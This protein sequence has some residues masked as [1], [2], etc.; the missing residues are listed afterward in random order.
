MTQREPTR[1]GEV[2]H[3]QGSTVTVAL[4]PDLAGT[5]P[6]FRGRLQLVG[7]I[8]SLVR[9][10]QG[11]IDLIAAVGLVGVSELSGPVAPAGSIQRDKRWIQVELLG[12]IDRGIGSFHRGVAAYP[13]LDDPVHFATT[14][15]L[16]SVFPHPDAR[17]LRL[18]RLAAAEDVPVC[19][20]AARF[21]VRH[22][23]IVGSTGSGKTSA[24]ASLLQ[25]FVREGWSASNIVV[26]DP[27]GEYAQALSGLA[28]VK[29]VLAS[30]DAQLRVPFWALPANEIARIFCG[31]GAVGHFA[32]A[33]R[34]L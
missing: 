17:H 26:I 2:R 24:V 19:V 12:S 11:P 30:G 7:Q 3:V 22:S 14:E 25:G 10:P 29:S 4:D 23:A 9:I 27:H 32:I 6:I 18:G 31:P 34:S 13:G 16:K 21:V 5:A 28:A 15:Q 33:F 1:I 8:G 20:E